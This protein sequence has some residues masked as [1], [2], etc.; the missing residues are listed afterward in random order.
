MYIAQ[1]FNV[2]KNLTRASRSNTGTKLYTNSIWVQTQSLMLAHPRSQRYLF[3]C[4]AI[5]EDLSGNSIKD[6]GSSS[7]VTRTEQSCRVVLRTQD[8]NQ[9]IRSRLRSW[10][11]KS[12]MARV[13]RRSPHSISFVRKARTTPLRPHSSCVWFFLTDLVNK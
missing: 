4:F 8:P 10:R 9:C 3:L 7:L 6:D 2:T 11:L 12:K 13:I 1:K 5:V